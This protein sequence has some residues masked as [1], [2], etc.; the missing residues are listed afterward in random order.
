MGG[1]NSSL[2][3]FGEEYSSCIV[4]VVIVGGNSPAQLIVHH[5]SD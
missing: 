3:R 2:K 1:L 4:L 5:L